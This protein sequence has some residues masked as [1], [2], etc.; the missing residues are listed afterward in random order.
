MSDEIE[1]LKKAAAEANSAKVELAKLQKKLEG[2]K[3]LAYEYAKEI[4]DGDRKK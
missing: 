3:M 4:E 2:I 1:K